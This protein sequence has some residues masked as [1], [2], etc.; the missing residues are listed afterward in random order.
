MN[1]KF[2]V[3]WMIEED[4]IVFEYTGALGTSNIDSTVTEAS[5]VND[6]KLTYGIFQ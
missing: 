2:N 1:D 4:M 3:A 6:E 5:Q